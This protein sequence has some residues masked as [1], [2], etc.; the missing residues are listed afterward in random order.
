MLHCTIRCVSPYAA[1]MSKQL[2]LSAVFST[3]ALAAFALSQGGVAAAR[4]APMETG[5]TIEA[6]AP[7]LPSLSAW[8]PFTN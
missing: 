1:A 7:A 4:F 8:A 6:A 5:A 2:R 3:L